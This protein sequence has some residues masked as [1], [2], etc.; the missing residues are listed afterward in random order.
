MSGS[1]ICFFVQGF[2]IFDLNLNC[3]EDG[4]DFQSRK[5]QIFDHFQKLNSADERIMKNEI[6]KLFEQK[7]GLFTFHQ[8]I[9]L[10]TLQ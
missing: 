4:R 7:K 10:R 9:E 3:L 2:L 1:E 6:A 8:V 5:D